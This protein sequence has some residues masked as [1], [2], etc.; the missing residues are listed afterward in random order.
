MLIESWPHEVL[1]HYPA[2]LRGV[3]AFLGNHGGFSGAQ[4]WRLDTCGGSYCLKAWPPDWRS[5]RE[6]AWIHGLITQGSVLPW[7]SRVAP[8]SAGTTFVVFQDRLWELVTWMPGEADFS[9]A[10]SSARLSAA[11]GALGQLHQA[12]APADAKYDVCPAVLRRFDSWQTWQ[13]LLQTGW[14]PSPPTID[15]YSPSAAQL[16]QLVL[17]RI[18]EVPRL[19]ARWSQR[20]IPL[21]PCVCD[22][23][24]DHVLFTGEAVT[25]LIDFGSVKED[26]VGVDLARLLG[27]LI[28]DDAALWESGFR[29]YERIRPFGTEERALARDLDRS[30]TILSA[31]HW[32]RWLYH[33]RRHYA[34]PAAVVNRLTALAR[35]LQAPISRL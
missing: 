33:E 20:K 15:P 4:L 11:C 3:L 1:S 5:P 23:W 28:G 10:P 31:T 7:M 18:D 29:A 34:R 9:L 25:G 27:S 21:Q 24:H 8:T 16:W 32:L 2:W 30:G 6:L 35:R 14:R 22:L 13:Q 26:H 12:W 17:R 19:L